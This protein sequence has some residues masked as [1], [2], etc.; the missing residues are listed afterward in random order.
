MAT[1]YEIVR[2]YENRKNYIR[3]FV[4]NSYFVANTKTSPALGR[5][6][7]VEPISV[8]CSSRVAR[9]FLVS[10]RRDEEAVTH[11]TATRINE[12]GQENI[13]NPLGYG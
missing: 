2:I 13:R 11:A 3:I 9:Y 4:R 1:K 8:I 6:G 5:L 7:G 10:A 12:A